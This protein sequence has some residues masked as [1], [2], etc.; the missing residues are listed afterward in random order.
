MSR[1]GAKTPMAGVFSGAVVVLALYAL[2]PAFYYIPESVLGAVVIHAVIDL[3]SGPV[4]LKE[5]WGYSVLE[6]IIF[7]A[8][9]IITCFL[10]VETAIYISIATSLF[11]MLLRL[12]RPKVISVGRVKLSHA[13]NVISSSSTSTSSTAYNK[14]V[15]EDVYA[16]DTSSRYIYVDEND[17][18]F[19]HLLNPLPPG[20]V[21]VQL[22]QSIL[23]PNANHV[24]ERISDIVKSRTRSGR[25]DQDYGLQEPEQAWN[26]PTLKEDALHVKPYLQC[27]VLDFS[28]VAILDA[29]ALHTLNSLKKTFMMYTR[30]REVE[31]HFCH[32]QPHVRQLLINAGFGTLPSNDDDTLRPPMYRLEQFD[33]ST[34]NSLCDP[35]GFMTI[36]PYYPSVHDKQP[37]IE[38]CPTDK[39]PG[40]HWDLESAI[41][42]ICIRRK[43]KAN[44]HSLVHVTVY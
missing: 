7:V 3:I 34:A 32:A 25:P 30:G 39:Y 20:V 6:F 27:I 9:V 37:V 4:F 18:N 26:Q 2:T 23:Y 5:L 10:D 19:K 31:W 35:M 33:E 42:S 12:A 44:D 1:S 43:Q 13:S 40:F 17:A 8:A 15:I 11:F 14:S 41:Y 29:T 16:I 28:S 24:T 21:V 36:D 38:M 22:S